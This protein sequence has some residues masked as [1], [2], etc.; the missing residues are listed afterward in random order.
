MAKKKPA[1]LRRPALDRL[2]N[3][4]PRLGPEFRKNSSLLRVSGSYPKLN[5]YGPLKPKANPNTFAPAAA[6]PAATTP[7]AAANTSPNA[8]PSAA[9]TAVMP[10]TMVNLLHFSTFVSILEDGGIGLI[11]FIE[12][13]VAAWNSG[14]RPIGASQ[15]CNCRCPRNA[16]HSS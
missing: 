16:K 14:N 8:A 12:N 13:S 6:T 2:S 5:R 1:T 4:G 15:G 10:M 3:P 11:E 7:V 9:A